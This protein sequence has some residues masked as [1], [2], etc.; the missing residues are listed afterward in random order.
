MR[1]WSIPIILHVFNQSL[2]KKTVLCHHSLSMAEKYLRPMWNV[3]G[4]RKKSNGLT[5]PTPQVLTLPP[6]THFSTLSPTL[7]ILFTWIMAMLTFTCNQ[8][9]G[10]VYMSQRK[11]EGNTEAGRGWKVLSK[12]T[13][14]I[15]WTPFGG[16]RTNTI[17]LVKQWEKKWRVCQEIWPIN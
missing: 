1:Y 4:G 8:C 12:D 3:E 6:P 15:H 14:T 13:S 16:F 7:A 17:F 9:F 10:L 2:H 5:S 11:L